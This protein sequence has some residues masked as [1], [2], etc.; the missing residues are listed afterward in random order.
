MEWQAVLAYK[1]ASLVGVAV[2]DPKKY[3]DLKKAF[4]GVFDSLETA[5]KQQPWQ[6]MK[7]RIEAHRKKKRG[8]GG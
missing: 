3:P 1:L 7:E 5:P 2:N 6:V 8:G 4:P